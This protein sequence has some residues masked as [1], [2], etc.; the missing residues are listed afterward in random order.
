MSDLI[1]RDL[2]RLDAPLGAEK[3]DVIRCLAERGRR[4]AA[5]RTSQPLA[6]DALA[7]EA[8][9]ATGLP[10]GI[11]IPH[12][13][14]AGVEEPTLAFA[15]LSPPVDFG[16]KDGAADLAFLIAAPEGGD[17]THLTLLTKL[18]R[19]AR[20]AGLHRGAARGRLR[21][22]GGRRSSSRRSA[23]RV[24]A[25]A[26]AH[27][28]RRRHGH[29]AAEPAP[30]PGVR[31]SL[32]AVTACPTGIA[33]TYMAAEALEAAAERAG[34]D[35][36]VETQGSAG[37]KPLPRDTIA[38]AAAVIFAVDVGV[39]DRQRF[40]GKPVVSSGVKRPIE[41]GDAMIAEALQ[42]ADDPHAPRVEGTADAAGSD[43]GRQRVVGC[44]RPPGA[45]DRC[46]VHDPV[47][48][49]R[50]PPDRAELPARR[51]RDRRPLRRHRGQSHALRPARPRGL[52]AR[53]RALRLGADGL[54]RR[55]VLHHRQDRVRAVHPGLR[56]LHRLRHRRPPGHRA[57]LR[58]GRPGRQPVRRADDRRHPGV[59][60][61]HGLPRRDRR[62]RA[63]GR[64]RPLD[65]RLEGPGLGTRPDARAGDPAADLHPGR[66]G[67]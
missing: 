56:R 16:A 57:R 6:A 19:A 44:A 3:A 67:R 30:A 20:Q 27:A 53:A 25:A 42:Y 21:S 54:P 60:P 48:R 41:E 13:R 59:L 43:V 8:T 38:Q 46:V 15:R 55:A 17:A 26:P 40:A 63:G 23:P 37:A 18:A 7:R 9:S 58:D 31:R 4:P 45:D 1:T 64:D 33:H 5:P 28:G 39:R 51:L 12:C 47:R 22:R 66:A 10:G 65:R 50:R 61:G 49:R 14:T 36:A 2:V 35:I 52:R 34:V 29:R 24:P 62:R 11:A 32:V